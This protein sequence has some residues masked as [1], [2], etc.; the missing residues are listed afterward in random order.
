[1]YWLRKVARVSALSFT[2]SHQHL[3]AAAAHV[4]YSLQAGQSFCA[5]PLSIGSRLGKP[6]LMLDHFSW[7]CA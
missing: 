1:V 4:K 3:P 5:G 7:K 2:A 6:A